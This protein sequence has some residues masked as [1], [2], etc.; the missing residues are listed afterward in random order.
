[1]GLKKPFKII[2]I[3]S[4][5]SSS[6]KINQ[7]IQNLINLQQKQLKRHLCKIFLLLRSIKKLN[8]SSQCKSQ[9]LNKIH[10]LLKSKT[11]NLV[12]SQVQEN[13]V[14]YTLQSN[15]LVNDRH[16]ATNFV[17]AIKKIE[18]D[19]VD[20]KL[21]VQLVREIKIQSF[22]NHPNIVKMYTFFSDKHYIYLML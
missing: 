16:K 8:F 18:K 12:P 5:W 3:F 6:I 13:S 22:L 19:N 21:V 15:I 14:K 17:C 2:P 10:V 11:F 1:M 7:K 4:K 20:S 9:L